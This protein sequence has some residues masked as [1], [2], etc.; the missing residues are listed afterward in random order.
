M[1]KEDANNG[2]AKYIAK[3]YLDWVAPNDGK[4]KKKASRPL[5]SPDI[6]KSRV[7]PMIDKGEKV[8]LIV[9]DNLRVDQWRILSEELAELFD[10]DEDFYMTITSDGNS[11]RSQCDIQ[12]TDA[13]SDCPNVSRLM[14]RRG[15]RRRQKPEREATHSNANRPLSPPR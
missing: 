14:G 7:F 10:I 12:R 1:Q 15:R 6:F 5:M 11:I 8:F 2:F 3:N 9:I 4:G 13:T